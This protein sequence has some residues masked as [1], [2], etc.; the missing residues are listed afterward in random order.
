[1]RPVLTWDLPRKAR[2][3][4]LLSTIFSLRLIQHCKEGTIGQN[5]RTP[6]ASLRRRSVGLRSFCKLIAPQALAMVSTILI[7]SCAQ[8]TPGSVPPPTVSVVSVQQKNV[9]I[10]GDWVATLEGFTTAQIQ[11]QVTGYL[12]KQDYRE[13]AL[14]HKDDVL[15]EID[16]RPF[17]AILDQAKGQ[18]AQAEAQLGLAVINVNRDTPVAQLHAIPQSQLDNDVQTKLAAEA[19]VQADQAAVEQAKLNLGFTQ[20]RS[21]IGGIA[22]IA[23]TQIGSLVATSTVLTTVSNVNPI[24]AYFP[25][26]EQEYLRIADRISGAVNLLST[27]SRVP[28]ELILANGSTY[29]SKGT[30]IFA[31]RQVDPQ[32]GTIRIVGAFPNPGNILRPGQFGRV[33]AVTDFRTGALLIP[34]RAVTELQGSYQV[35]V[36]EQ[37][38]KVSI[39]TVTVAERVGSLWIV[40]TGLKPGD[41]VVTEGIQKVANG[42]TVNPVPDSSQDGSD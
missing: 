25:I 27:T 7:A 18:L 2:Y 3:L 19:T 15:F 26:S 10:Y 38:N 6:A 32:T 29:T 16:P 5:P 39:R 34:Q 40:A 41:R 35:A 1:M 14:V 8:K 37:D 21:L 9:P 30:I 12:I 36:V 20:V 28:L 13:G 4:E 17:Q 24:K 23:Q 31:D 33:R 11:P 42:V 22:G